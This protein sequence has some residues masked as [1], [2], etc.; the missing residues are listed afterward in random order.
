MPLEEL[1]RY[2]LIVVEI[3]KVELSFPNDFV[4]IDYFGREGMFFDTIF[5]GKRG[6]TELEFEVFSFL[7]G[8]EVRF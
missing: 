8:E 1:E 3:V 2:I 6:I 4:G 5:C 7:G